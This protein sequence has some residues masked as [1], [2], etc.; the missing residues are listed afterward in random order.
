MEA[1]VRTTIYTLPKEMKPIAP[2]VLYIIY[3]Y[4]YTCRLL[5]L[6]SSMNSEAREYI[7][8]FDHVHVGPLAFID[9][10]G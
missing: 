3:T 6:G 2:N 9:V 8:D 7:G 10:E 5:L 1:R 4:I